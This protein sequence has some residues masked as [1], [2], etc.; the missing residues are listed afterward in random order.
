MKWFPKWTLGMMDEYQLFLLF[1]APVALC[2]W[3]LGDWC[4]CF[5]FGVIHE[6]HGILGYTSPIY[7]T[8]TVV[9][10]DRPTVLSNYESKSR[11]GMY[12]SAYTVW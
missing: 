7:D 4:S 1:F 8:S 11:N 6:W 5:P 12:S 9:D 3:G 2:H 10:I